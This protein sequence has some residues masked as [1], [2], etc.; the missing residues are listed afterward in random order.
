M[1]EI[2]IFKNSQFGAM[3]TVQEN[4]KT[5]F[6]GSDVAKALGYRNAPDAIKK[7]CKFDG[8]VKCDSVDKIGRKNTL[9]FISEGNVYRLITHSKLPEAEKFEKWVFDEVLP[10]IHRTGGYVNNDDSFINTYLPFADDSTKL[11]FKG[12]LETVRSLNAQIDKDRP[13]VVFADAVTSSKTSI[14]IGELAKLIK[15]NGV[16]IGEKR[17][18]AWLRDNGYLIR[19]KGTD[20]NAP[21]QKSMEMKLF[22]VK[23]TAITH[24]DGHTTINKTTKV[25]GKG[26]QYFINKFLAKTAEVV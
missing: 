21:T 10:T 25:T 19:R 4:S 17:L 16:Q 18:F 15:Q 12:T 13:K 1:N 26:Q 8:I 3:R 24:A 23:E 7:H 11:L 5:Y 20:Y 2:Q 6:C 14:L 9:S 22:E